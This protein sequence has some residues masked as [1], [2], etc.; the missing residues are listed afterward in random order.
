MNDMYVNQP[1]TLIQVTDPHFSEQSAT[2]LLGLDTDDSFTKVRDQALAERG[3]ADWLLVT[4]DLSN[5]GSLASYQR[6]QQQSQ[7]LA[8]QQRW[9]PGNHDDEQA[10]CVAVGANGCLQ[11]NIMLP[12]WSIVLL[13][14]A[15]PG[16]VG[17]TLTEE[18]LLFLSETLAQSGD[19]HVMVCLHHHPVA[20][21]CDWLDQQQVS[22]ADKLFEILDRFSNVKA[23]LWGH[24]HQHIDLW[25]KGV[26]LLATPS[27]CLQFAANSMEF[28]LSQEQPGYRWLE[29]YAD[30]RLETGVERLPQGSVVVD[31]EN[32]EGY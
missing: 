26:R 24:V 22:N 30:G 3:V 28:K 29:L 18:E 6:F 20:C 31:A 5:D 15:V 12:H 23:V 4:G 19:R 2:T 32:S 27:C 14:S 17:G 9:L 16:Q 11:K 1:V 8:R 21:G 25:R 13:N 7:P 10:M